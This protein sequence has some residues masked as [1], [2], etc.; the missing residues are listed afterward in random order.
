MAASTSGKLPFGSGNQIQRMVPVS[1]LDLD[2][3]NARFRDDAANQ[4]Q[5]LEFMLA[6]AGE[7]CLGL[8]KDMC[9]I[10]E[11]NPSDIPIVV[12]SEN[13]YRMLEG[14]RRLTCLKIWRKP[15]LLNRLPLELREKYKKRFENV[16][17]RASYDPPSSISV[18][19]VESVEDADEWIDKKHGLGR[20]SGAATA[21]WNSF[22]KDRRRFR[23]TNK[24]S[25]SFSFVD[26]LNAEYGDDAEMM[27]SLT[28]LLNTQYTILKRVLSSPVM[29]EDIG[30]R[31]ESNG[32]THM[33]RTAEQM[34]PFLVRL[35]RDLAEQKVDSR[36]LDTAQDT[37]DYLSKLLEETLSDIPKQKLSESSSSST[38]ASDATPEATASGSD[39]AQEE[40]NVEKEDG[41]QTDGKEPR[42]PKV[43]KSHA[44][45]FVDLDLDGFSSKTVDLVKNTTKLSVNSNP[46]VIAI[47]LRVILDITC[48]QFLDKFYGNNPPKDLDKRILEVL[49]I[50]DPQATDELH[51][52]ENARPFN[53][54]FHTVKGDPN[55]L[56]LAQFAVHSS[57]FSAT[58]EETKRLADRYEPM[59]VAMNE[60]MRQNKSS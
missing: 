1:K 3:R 2:L 19:I 37:S 35:L 40:T 14:N 53:V 4:D 52:A 24:K 36:K 30:I 23:R 10:G 34:R 43:R 29:R 48:F 42:T 55:H 41:V 56:K 38:L 58:A 33:D 31:Y 54:L 28:T 20:E 7:K 57:T 13:R 60:R 59:L 15:A 16:I 27:Q 50:L 44:K 6:V 11:L 12:V 49:K 25:Q 18:V 45:I 39:S 8:L 17:K 32:R 51:H 22:E 47:L 9:T 21:D 46:D 5:A 26:M